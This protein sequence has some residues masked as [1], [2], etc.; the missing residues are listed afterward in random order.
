MKEENEKLKVRVR[1]LEAKF[2]EQNRDKKKLNIVIKGIQ[3]QDALVREKVEEVLQE[4]ISVKPEIREVFRVGKVE[5]SKIIVVT[6]ETWQN[7]IEII[8]KKKTLKGTNIRIENDLTVKEREIQT[9]IKAFAEKAR[10]EGKR[11][12]IVRYQK[13]IVDGK[14]WK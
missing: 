3:V 5:A 10:N 9:Y 12:K 1:N 11:A 8:K 14:E 7:K 4:K 13:L 6:I 2:E